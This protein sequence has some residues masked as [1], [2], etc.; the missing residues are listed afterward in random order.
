MRFKIQNCSSLYLN[1]LIILHFIPLGFCFFTW[2]NN[3][4]THFWIYS[5][6]LKQ[7]LEL[8]CSIPGLGRTSG[9]GHGNT[10]QYSCLENPHGQGS[11]V[12]YNPWGHKE[13]DT[14]EQLSTCSR[15]AS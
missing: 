14:T 1:K 9:G 2:K 4:L 3:R 8:L 5:E 10:F 13:S 7:I 6:I 12:G 11:L 15:W